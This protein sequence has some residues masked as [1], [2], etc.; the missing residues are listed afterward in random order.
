MR[1]PAHGSSGRARDGRR[2]RIRPGKVEPPGRAGHIS[3]REDPQAGEHDGQ[4]D[5]HVDQE[6]WPPAQSEQ[7]GGDEQAAG[8]LADDRAAGQRDRV[9]AERAGARR[10]L[11]DVQLDAG[12]HL[13]EGE[14]PADALHHP[15]GH[16]DD[17]IGRQPARQRRRP[18]HAKPGEEHAAVA[19]QVSQPR[20]GDEQRRRG[21]Q[22][23]ADD[24]FELGARRAQVR[25]DRRGGDVHDRRV[26]LV[27]EQHGE[28]DRQL[29]ALIRCRRR[30]HTRQTRPRTGT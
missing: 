25:A 30:P 4:G 24:Q 6:D 1:Q 27:H 19:A 14:R 16:Q 17:R 28:Q 7:I 10:A 20:T 29:P 8:D 21:Q 11:L 18:E 3:S 5:R 12:Q 23:A 13:G 9:Q 2:P 26:R 22:V 15:A